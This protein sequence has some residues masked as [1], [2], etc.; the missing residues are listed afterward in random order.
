MYEVMLALSGADLRCFLAVPVGEEVRNELARWQRQVRGQ[1][2]NAKWV[3]PQNYH[4]T[5]K[6]YGQLP[7]E[8]V[9]ELAAALQ[10]P[11][12]DFSSFRTEISG[13]GAFPDWL[14]P[15][16]M[17]AGVGEGADHLRELAG[18]VEAVSF[19]I[20]VPADKRDYRPHLTIARFRVPARGSDIPPQVMAAR[21]RH[22]G[23]YTTD[24]VRLMESKLTSNGAVYSPLYTFPLAHGK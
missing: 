13:F 23:L 17:W 3:D 9:D 8:A 11:L 10:K 22:W 20:N 6:F 4:I 5:I 2:P 1:L 19:G 16:V 12:T 14:H 7:P 15:R 24:Q 21:A 18:L